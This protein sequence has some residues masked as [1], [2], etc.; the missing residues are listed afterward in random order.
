MS[1]EPVEKEFTFKDYFVPLTTTK[2]I[3]F[4]IIIGIVVYANALFNG[5]IADD[6]GQILDNQLV[7]SIGNFFT[8]FTW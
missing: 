2:A 1:K 4:I 6:N 7:H 5:F 8:F 3:H